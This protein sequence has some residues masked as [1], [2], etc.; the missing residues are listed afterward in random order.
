[1]GA[2]YR[3]W[4]LSLNIP[5]ALK[6]MIPEPGIDSGK[7]AE[8]RDQFRREAHVLAN[9]NH[10]NLPRVTNFFQWYGNAYLVMDFVEGKSLEQLIERQGAIPEATVMRWA[11]QLLDAL[12]ACHTHRIIHRDIKPQNIIIRTD[13]Q[14]V[15]VDFGLAKLWDPDHPRT[16]RIIRGMGT[17][18]Y[19]S[20]EHFYVHGRHTEPRSDIYSLGA[21]LY[22]AL[23]GY[24]P[25]SAI[26]RGGN[27]PL[28]SQ[29]LG[30]QIQPQTER[31]ILR[32]MSLN[33]D[34][35]FTNARDMQ[36]TLSSKFNIDTRQR[37][38]PI[39]TP[40]IQP[41]PNAEVFSKKRDTYPSEPLTQDTNW[42]LEMGVS[43]I[44]AAI[45]MLAVQIGLYAPFMT[46]DLYVGRT[47][48]ALL[49]GAAGWFVGDLIFQ[50]MAQPEATT[51]STRSN[52]PTERLVAL[53]RRMTRQM[54][55]GQQIMLLGVLLIG[56]TVLTWL[57][58]PPLLSIPFIYD[59]V[60]FYALVGPL[61]YA[62]TGRRPGR[63]IVAHTLVVT[64][65]GGLL[66]TRLN[67]SQNISALFM[68][69]IVGG[70]LM[71]GIAYLVDQI[72]L[73]E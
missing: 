11:S 42:V 56:A 28:P 44:M 53:T 12:H 40:G 58:A 2:V 27:D 33:P 47:L 64:V 36:A 3:A 31:I 48:I 26:E 29:G 24:E 23:T 51:S 46:T 7:L 21:T 10:P 73:H 72:L 61:A 55:T 20:P 59:Y 60:Q 69:A 43:M 68:V 22:H 57:L 37:S 45:G 38:E 25:P 19:A 13:E 9:L 67:M 8:L 50:A 71:E 14:A 66:G 35:R 32:A 63:A 4:D 17:R 41:N 54:T 15:L 52:R 6:E 34:Q 30:G 49:L 18:A 16:Q 39:R 5:V 1:M 65:V 70:A 62:A